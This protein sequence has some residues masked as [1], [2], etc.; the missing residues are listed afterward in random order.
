MP[1]ASSLAAAKRE[2]LIERVAE[3]IVPSETDERG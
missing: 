1:G 3:A 2:T